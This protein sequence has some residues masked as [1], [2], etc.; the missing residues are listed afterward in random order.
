M[1]TGEIAVKTA[2]KWTVPDNASEYTTIV[3]EQMNKTNEESLIHE[4]RIYRHLALV[5]GVL[6][7]LHISDTEIRMPYISHRSLDKYMSATKTVGATQ[8]RQYLAWFRNAADIISRVHGQ[9]VIVAD[10][11]ARNF[12]VNKDLSLQLCDFSE[13]LIIPEDDVPE[14]FLSEDFLSVKF[15]IARF[16]SMMYE[17]VSGHRYEFYIN[18]EIDS[19]LDEGESKT[20]KEWPTSDRFP[21]TSDIF[22][23]DIIR[24]CWRRDGFCNM[25]DVCA[26]LQMEAS[27]DWRH[28]VRVARPIITTILF[29][30]IVARRLPWRKAVD[31]LLFRR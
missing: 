9:R 22:F 13:S 31:A 6:Q 1:R 4:G 19:D 21:D 20:Y 8:H 7:P 5:E 29:S 26:A 18:P 2:N 14:E 12:L 16:G 25:E 23:G 11:A 27:L 10:I 15:D 3:Y 30:M 17:I 28:I 24:K